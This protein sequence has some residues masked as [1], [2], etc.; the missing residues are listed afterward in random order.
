MNTEN[1]FYQK[2]G[3]MEYCLLEKRNNIISII[4]TNFFAKTI[5]IF[6]NKEKY[7]HGFVCANSFIKNDNNINDFVLQ[8]NRF[9]KDLKY[10]ANLSNYKVLNNF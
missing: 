3:E 4:K 9:K 7:V 1:N 8:Y 2:I 6:N 10:F 5:I